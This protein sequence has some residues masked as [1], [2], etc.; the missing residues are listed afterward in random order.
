VEKDLASY[1]KTSHA[2]GSPEQGRSALDA[3]ELMNAGV[4][5]M[6]ATVTE[7]ISGIPMRRKFRTS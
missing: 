6:R 2:A 1:G 7:R 4:N 3:V 5:F